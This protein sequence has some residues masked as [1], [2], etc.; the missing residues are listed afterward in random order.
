MTEMTDAERT[1]LRT[2]QD[3]LVA[4]CDRR[5]MEAGR[6]LLGGTGPTVTQ[7]RYQLYPCWAA[8]IERV[9]ATLAGRRT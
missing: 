6:T 7:L 2:L 5:G 8:D 1:A 3:K 9:Y 4:E